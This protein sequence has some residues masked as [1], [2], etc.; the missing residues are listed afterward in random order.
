[1]PGV[2]VVNAAFARVYFDGQNPVGRQAAFRPR[3]T[4]QVPFE[5]VGVVSDSV[6][7]DV[8]EP[9]R[10]IVYLPGAARGSGTFSIRTSGDPLTFASSIRR[11]IAEG[12]PNARMQA[13]PMTSLVRRQ[14][15]RERLLATLTAFFAVV[16]LLLA[17]IGLYGVLSYAVVQQRREIGVR[18]ALGARAMHV[19]TRVSSDMGVIVLAGALIGL[20]AGLGFGRLIER[21][22]FEVKAIDPVPLVIPLITLG[23]AAVFAAV[24]PILRAVHVDPSQVLRAE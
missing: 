15:I 17:C 4:V 23:L 24:P 9:M 5:I 11:L 2:A 7:S 13:V 8:R 18:M 14:M 3:S 22:L 16:A 10:P 12:R 20:A 1:V 21:L 19:A 6:Y